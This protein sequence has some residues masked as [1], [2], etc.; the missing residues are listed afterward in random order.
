MKT[1]LTKTI[2]MILVLSITLILFSACVGGSSN[3]SGSSRKSGLCSVCGK[4]ATMTIDGR[5]YC[6]KHYNQK[7][8]G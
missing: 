3:G 1:T 7:L 6:F 4:E 8:L 2:A 5:Y